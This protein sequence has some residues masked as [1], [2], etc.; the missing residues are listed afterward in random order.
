MISAQP[1]AA[2][3]RALRT[4]RAAAVAGVL[5]ALL[6]TALVRLAAP[7]GPGDAGAW[8]SDP[9]RRRLVVVA[10]NRVPFAAIAFL[11]F[12]LLAAALL[13]G[14]GTPLHTWDV[15][16]AAT[17]RLTPF[18]RAALERET[19]AVLG[20][21]A[22]A[23][24][25][26]FGPSVGHALTGVLSQASP[27][28]RAI[29]AYQ[30]LSRLNEQGLAAQ[31][32]DLVAGFARSGILE[33]DLLQRIGVRL[34]ASY[35][36]QPGLAEFGQIVGDKFEVAGWKL[37]KTRLTTLRLWLQ[38]WDARTGQLLWESSGEVTVA[39]QLLTQDAAVSLEDIAQ[40]LWS[41][42]IQ[43]DLL[44]GATRSRFLLDSK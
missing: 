31:Y 2:V 12:I 44:G 41:S 36:L 5:F 35:V 1:D 25:Q 4:P 24:L 13:V 42:M 18:D 29:P 14:C 43:D 9:G 39:A 22:P 17:P 3:T 6:T 20:L 40:R 37:L 7:T 10:L 38:L 19:V 32:G 34:G 33:R 23:A 28:I 11:W 21:A 16:T 27:P 30:T 8:V 26:G 15:H